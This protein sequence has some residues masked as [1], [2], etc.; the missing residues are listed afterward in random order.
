MLLRGMFAFAK[1]DKAFC[2]RVNGANFV[3]AGEKSM[4]GYY[5]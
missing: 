5:R 3:E 1:V 4:T 2:L